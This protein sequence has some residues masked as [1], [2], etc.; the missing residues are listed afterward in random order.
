MRKAMND[1]IDWQ[2][3]K[4]WK[5]R[6]PESQ[7]NAIKIYMFQ[8]HEDVLNN[9]VQNYKNTADEKYNGYLNRVTYKYASSQDAE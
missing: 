2:I 4:N 8:Q 3:N 7:K 9:L 5:L 1:E 6:L